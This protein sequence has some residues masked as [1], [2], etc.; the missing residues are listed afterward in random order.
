MGAGASVG[1]VIAREVGRVA[2]EEHRA[3]TRGEQDVG[4]VSEMSHSVVKTR[5]SAQIAHPLSA[6]VPGIESALLLI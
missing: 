4:S 1:R 2:L 6:N 5:P 3:A